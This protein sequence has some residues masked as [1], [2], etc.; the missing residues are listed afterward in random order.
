LE[1]AGKWVK[2]LIHFR[3]ETSHDFWV[4]AQPTP[5]PNA[6]SQGKTF[7]ARPKDFGLVRLAQRAWF[8]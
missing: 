6:E 8:V 4:Q 7:C 3:D 5:S 1:V 2:R